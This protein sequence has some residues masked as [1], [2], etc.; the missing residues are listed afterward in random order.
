M[1][2]RYKIKKEIDPKEINEE[3]L[4]N[5]ELKKKLTDKMNELF[6]KAYSSSS[7]VDRSKIG[8]L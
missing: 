2:T 1:P 6:T 5:P 3:E 7:N 8:F 4:S